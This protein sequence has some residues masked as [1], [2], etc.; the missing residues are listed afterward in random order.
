MEVSGKWITNLIRDFIEHSPVNSLG[1]DSNKKAWA[2]PLVGFSNGADSLYDFYKKDIGDF[3]LTP[4]DAF[5]QEFPQSQVRASDLTVVTWILPQTDDTKAA[6][7]EM[8]IFPSEEWMRA[9][10][11]GE[12]VN[13]ML[14]KYV[15]ESL[16]DEGQQAVAPV[17]S[18]TFRE[19][20]SEKYNYA[21]PWS[22]RHAAYA[23]GLGTFGLCDGLITPKGK[24]MRCGS[25]IV[26][27]EIPPSERPY[28]NHRA[29]CLFFANESCTACIDQCPIQAIS[30]EGHDKDVCVRHLEKAKTRAMKKYGFGSDACGLCQVDVPCESGIPDKIQ[31]AL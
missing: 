17:L 30:K 29:Y 19:I 26:D 11:F 22:E 15:V 5:V 10:V 12:R 6:Q 18:P 21:S 14:R 20:I 25:V 8:T 31:D 13:D 7:R 16:Q 2:E 24:A 9:K 27:V 1:K 23:A 28:S 3:F 4:H